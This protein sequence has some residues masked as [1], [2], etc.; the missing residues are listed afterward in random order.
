MKRLFRN[1]L[2]LG[3]LASAVFVPQAGA[4]PKPAVAQPDDGQALTLENDVLR[5]TVSPI[6]ARLLGFYDK[7][8]QREE[9][10]VLPEVGGLNEVRAKSLGV[11]EVKA[12][13]QLKKEVLADGSQKV[14]AFIK[15]DGGGDEASPGTMKKEYVLRPGSSAL[16]VAV[17]VGNEG[18]EEIGFF[19]WVRHL[20]MKRGTKEL[21]EQAFMSPQGAFS[22]VQ[23]RPWDR[24]RAIDSHEHYFPA[25]GWTSR[26]AVP[27]EDGGNTL[28]TV[29][30]PGDLFKIYNWRK[31]GEDYGTQEVIASPLYVP[32]GE[33]RRW[34][35]VIGLAAPVRNVVLASP[36]LVLGCT[37]HPTWIPADAKEITLE[38]AATS[39][40][41][42]IKAN[43]VLV[44]V[45]APQ[46]SLA[47]TPFDLPAMGPEGTVKKTIPLP[48]KDGLRYQLKLT[49]TRDGRT[50]HPGDS[51]GDKDDVIIPLIVG[52]QSKVPVVFEPRTGRNDRLRRIGSTERAAKLVAA[53]K[54]FEVFA[55]PA[56]QR[57]FRG[58]TFSVKEQGPAV[59]HGA[60]GEYESLQLV[61]VPK[62]KASPR[63]RIETT[64]LTGPDGAQIACEGARKFLYAHTETPSGYNAL[65]AAGDYPEALLPTNELE[66]PQNSNAPL[67]VTYHV[68][69]DAKPGLY[70]G[71]VRL[72]SD[73]G[74]AELP[75]EFN[76]WNFKLPKRSRYMEF[77]SSLKGNSLPEAK[78]PDGSSLTRQEQAKL[79]EDMH[80]KYRLTPCDSGLGSGLFAKDRS[81]FETR[82]QEFASAGATKIY[83]GGIPQLLKIHGDRM[84]EIEAYLKQKGWTDYFYVRPGFDEASQD[85][86]P[87]I[88]KVCLDWKKVSSIPIMETYYHDQRADE[89][90]G[91]IDIWS[92]S[93]P[94]PPW[95]AERAAAGDRFWKVNAM[96]GHL[97]DEP[98]KAARRRY[99]E[100][101]DNHF[102]GS[103]N[104]TVKDWGGIKDW[105]ESI[106]NDHGVGNLEAILMW[107]HETGILSTIR[108]EAMRDGLE[109]NALLWMLREKVAALQGIAPKDAA[110][111]KAL[112][113][114]RA[115]CESG[116]LAPNLKTIANLLRVRREAGEALSILNTK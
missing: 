57:V 75:V 66:V 24:A 4:E 85:R 100:M 42:G 115:L 1:W 60:A 96:P 72:I 67:F 58:D 84:P 52:A 36:A 65:Y 104:W 97:E 55:T 98:W 40:L 71:K 46:Q 3:Y 20:I 68:P 116:P 47:S 17:E 95:Y 15:T 87:E 11:N 77:A 64:A 14:T 22:S 39:K 62:G 74:T 2:S 33:T 37:P 99:V 59:L 49:F 44:A 76:V 106:W 18:K 45:D 21:P 27:V 53:S 114:A 105:K 56:S 7:L 38:F 113:A 48:L 94:A 61:A 5:V 23:N 29:T 78:H 32:P 13:Y 51:L 10:K 93:F 73:A 112:E 83:L 28:F 34:N 92:R 70:R 16:E 35:Y 102:T 31:P 111:A 41:A 110:H 19:P 80:L 81:A 30:A 103:Y 101:W 54:E 86:V 25:D 12:V 43:A 89:L 90:F 79:I 6:G 69:E 63:L 108:L 9:S 26:L 88:A 109:D 91:L 82:M 107:P 8:R 50:F